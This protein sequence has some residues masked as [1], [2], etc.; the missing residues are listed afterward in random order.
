MI[1]PVRRALFGLALLFPFA[2][3]AQNSRA[4]Q[5]AGINH[6]ALSVARQILLHRFIQCG[7]SLYIYEWVDYDTRDGTG[8]YGLYLPAGLKERPTH[9]ERQVFNQTGVILWFSEYRGLLEA[10]VLQDASSSLSQAD[11]L[12]GLQWAGQAEIDSHLA[13]V[14]HRDWSNGVWGPWGTTWTPVAKFPFDIK[15]QNG[16]WF[17]AFDWKPEMPVKDVLATPQPA[18][19]D[20]PIR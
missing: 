4:P 12:N 11:R 10:L 7:T 17:V 15:K 20:L 2:F 16:K 6:E 14:H 19:A 3:Y 18:C 8:K 13:A 9:D 5:I 1:P